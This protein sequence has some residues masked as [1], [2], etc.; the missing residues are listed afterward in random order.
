MRVR[1]V[2]IRA[3]YQPGS[4]PDSRRS[5]QATIFV[6]IGL[7]VALYSGCGKVTRESGVSATAAST[8]GMAGAG[9]ESCDAGTSG[10]ETVSVGD[11]SNMT[12]LWDEWY[13]W[14]ELGALVCAISETCPPTNALAVLSRP[15]DP[16]ASVTGEPSTPNEGCRMTDYYFTFGRFLS[17]AVGAGSVHYDSASAQRCVQEVASRR[18]DTAEDLLFDDLD[19]CRSIFVG[20]LSA[21][22]A[23]EY[24]V[25][26]ME[27][28]FCDRSAACP[29][30]CAPRQETGGSC[31]RNAQ[32]GAGLV[33]NG[34][35]ACAP[36]GQLDE[37]CADDRDCDASL[38]CTV[39]QSGVGS[40]DHRPDYYNGCDGDPCD[41][42]LD[43]NLESYCS[44][45]TGRCAPK[46]GPGGECQPEAFTFPCGHDRRAALACDPLGLVPRDSNPT[47]TW[48]PQ[49]ERGY[50]CKVPEGSPTGSCA[51]QQPL[52]SECEAGA[53]CTTAICFQRNCQNPGSPGDRCSV[54]T[55]CITGACDCVGCQEGGEGM[56]E[57]PYKTCHVPRPC[58]EQAQ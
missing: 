33:C 29:G 28:H 32:C 24:D 12:E 1:R 42:H 40:C 38:V 2:S 52:V 30:L 23:C 54:G 36:P 16:R 26:C 41:S 10:S 39:S 51:V 21:G 46:A 43:C 56:V 45:S 11:I 35:R 15:P 17:D 47:H 19:A 18:C 44:T 49:C 25:E 22:A 50:F 34:Q 58:D 3:M 31:E 9:A 8:G 37:P 7:G 27:G 13:E 4:M 57:G 5:P 20:K 14:Y 48:H 53:E 6:V 55:Q